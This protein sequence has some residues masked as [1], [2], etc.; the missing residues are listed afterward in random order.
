MINKSLSLLL[1]FLSGCASQKSVQKGNLDPKITS[2]V[3]QVYKFVTGS[4]HGGPI[5]IKEDE[6]Y[7]SEMERGLARVRSQFA[8]Y[9]QPQ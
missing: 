1:V 9:S 4:V 7:V 2:Y 8:P 6:R 5:R 3:S